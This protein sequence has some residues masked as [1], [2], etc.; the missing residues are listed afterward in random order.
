VGDDLSGRAIIHRQSRTRAGI[1]KLAVH[2][3]AMGVLQECG[4]GGADRR[5]G[6][7]A[8]LTLLDCG[9]QSG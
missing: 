4:C 9:K 3:W 5:Y 1:D 7:I 2:E 6:A 8:Q